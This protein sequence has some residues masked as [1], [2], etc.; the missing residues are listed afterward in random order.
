MSIIFDADIRDADNA[1]LLEN[2]DVRVLVRNQG[3]HRTHSVAEL[4]ET[5]EVGAPARIAPQRILTVRL[6]QGPCVPKDRGEADAQRRIS[7]GLLR[8]CVSSLQ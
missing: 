2:R 3:P 7:S 6:L 8:L 1:S 4:E 5:A